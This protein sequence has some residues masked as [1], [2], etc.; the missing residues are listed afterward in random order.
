MPALK[1]VQQPHHAQFVI[2]SV[3]DD[4]AASF[5]CESRLTIGAPKTARRAVRRTTTAR[6]ST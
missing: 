1:V 6:R 4:I 5:D 2:Y 3:P